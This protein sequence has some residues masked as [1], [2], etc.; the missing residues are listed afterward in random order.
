MFDDVSIVLTI[1]NIR[2][3]C[4]NTSGDGRDC[5]NCSEDEEEVAEPLTARSERQ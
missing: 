4:Q 2:L 5:D 3:T 1:F